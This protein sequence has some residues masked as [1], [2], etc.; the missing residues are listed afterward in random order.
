MP[1]EL[2]NNKEAITMEMVIEDFVTQEDPAIEQEQEE[3]R[4]INPTDPEWTEFVMSMLTDNEKIG[5]KPKA[6]G[7]LRICPLVYANI[8]Q[9]VPD[10][11]VVTEDYA[12][13]TMHISFDNGCT[14]TGSAEVSMRNCGEPY[15]RYP[16]GSAT[17]RALGRALKTAMTLNVLTAEE[18]NDISVRSNEPTEGSIK[19]SDVQINFIDILCSPKKLNINIK[20]VVANIIGPDVKS[21]SK[22][23]HDDALV[24]QKQL[25]V[26]LKSKDDMPKF[27]VY[28]SEWR[29]NFV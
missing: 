18:G 8:V 21:I 7:L 26:W 15:N 14:I 28:D 17:T 4:D 22:L 16:L 19:I 1:S 6:L 11:H 5:N 2:E 10:V 20:E 25:D 24:I 29:S 9:I 3:E 23:T 12:A 27:G 13:V